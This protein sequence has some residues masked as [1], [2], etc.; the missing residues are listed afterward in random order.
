MQIPLV[1]GRTVQRRRHRVDGRPCVVDRRVP[2]EAA[3]SPDRSP[4]GQQ[5]QR[6]GPR[7]TAS[8]SSASSARSTASTSASRSRRSASTIPRR[9]RPP[10]HDGAR[11]SRPASTRRRSCRRCARRCR[12]SIPSSRSPTCGRWTSGWRD[13]SQTRRAPML[14]L[15][16]FGAVALVLVGDRHLRRA[17]VRRR[18]ARARVRHPPGARRRPRVDPLAGAEAGAAT[19]GFGIGARTA[20]RA[21]AHALAADAAVRREPRT[22]RRCS[23]A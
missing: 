13:R 16:L 6:G 3:T 14:L 20:R 17:G 23:P 4:L 5:I 19:A 8:P 18:A 15:A 22:I 1:A 7:P 11:R 10:R 21:R 12:R 9:S 2:G